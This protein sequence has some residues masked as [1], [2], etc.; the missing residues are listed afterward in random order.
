V[1]TVGAGLALAVVVAL[2]ATGALFVLGADA[3]APGPASPT[4]ATDPVGAGPST[5]PA[6][7]VVV[8]QRGDT[9]WGI[10]RRLQPSGDVRPLVDALADRAGGA[11]LSVGQRLDVTGLVD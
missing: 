10:A 6:S 1:A 3:A 11:S 4:V 8:V 7:T 9:L 2:A 5:T